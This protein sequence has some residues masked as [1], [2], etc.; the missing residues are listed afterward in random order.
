MGEH[1]FCKISDGGKVSKHCY[2]KG[3]LYMNCCSLII[4]CFQIVNKM[5]LKAYYNINENK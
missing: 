1:K 2:I 3:L 5:L 4:Y